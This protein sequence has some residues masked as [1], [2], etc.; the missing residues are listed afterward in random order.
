MQEVQNNRELSASAKSLTHVINCAILRCCRYSGI[1]HIA[2][3]NHLV[4]LGY[5]QF[6]TQTSGTLLGSVSLLFCISFLRAECSQ[7]YLFAGLQTVREGP[8]CERQVEFTEAGGRGI[9]SEEHVETC[10]SQTL[11][12][13][14]VTLF[15][16]DPYNIL[17]PQSDCLS[18]SQICHCP[19]TKSA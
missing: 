5:P 18:S 14:H 7:R 13:D 4:G 12:L 2:F 11:H 3:Q 19:L 6:M 10:R 1:V 16:V 9:P 8:L 15:T 17:T